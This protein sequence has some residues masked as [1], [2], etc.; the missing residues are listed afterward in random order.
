MRMHKVNRKKNVRRP[1]TK[2]LTTQHIKKQTVQTKTSKTSEM[3][4]Q[5]S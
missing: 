5:E 2:E 4:I 3:E 1:V